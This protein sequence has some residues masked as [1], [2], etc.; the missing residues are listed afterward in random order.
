MPAPDGNDRLDEVVD[1]MVD[2]EVKLA[3]Q[4]RMLAALD[5][6]VRSQAAR[7]DA[8]VRRIDALEKPAEE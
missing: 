6:V 2:L 7:I 3:Y 8:L 1:R 4:D 5:E